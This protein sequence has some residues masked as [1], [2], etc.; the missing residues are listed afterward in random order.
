MKQEQEFDSL[1][2][3]G[4]AKYELYYLLNW[5]ILWCGTGGS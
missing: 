4:K 2:E 3:P 5:E 1:K